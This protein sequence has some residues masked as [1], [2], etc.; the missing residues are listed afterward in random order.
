MLCIYDIIFIK[1]KK[2]V[3]YERNFYS[4]FHITY[5]IYFISN[6]YLKFIS[7]IKRFLV[8]SHTIIFNYLSQIEKRNS[9][10][11]FPD[12]KN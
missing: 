5:A 9:T 3:T 2:R 8:P 7:T 1:S 4:Q 12:I 6:I 10:A 11:A